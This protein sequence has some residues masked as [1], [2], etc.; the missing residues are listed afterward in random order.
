M[1]SLQTSPPAAVARAI[2]RGPPGLPRSDATASYT[3]TVSRDCVRSSQAELPR[4]A[5]HPPVIP[6][7]FLHGATPAM[8]DLRPWPMAARDRLLE[9]RGDRAG[10]GYDAEGSSVFGADRARVPGTPGRRWRPAFTG[11]AGARGC[12]RPVP[13]R[14]AATG[15]RG[16]SGGGHCH[17]GLA[18]GLRRFAVE[19]VTPLPSAVGRCLAVAAAT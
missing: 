3:L 10:W 1:L 19:P 12:Q 11:N 15:R 8:R 2:W 16:R 7:C 18:D 6:R 14:V 5:R 13:G 9:L 4:P 17:A